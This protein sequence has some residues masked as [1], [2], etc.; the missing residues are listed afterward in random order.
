MY[1][2][3]N[4]IETKCNEMEF[5]EYDTQS[6]RPIPQVS[7]SFSAVLLLP[8]SAVFNCGGFIRTWPL[9]RSIT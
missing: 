1:N 3:A 4:H 2:I 5:V 7:Y 8:V 9:L 6:N